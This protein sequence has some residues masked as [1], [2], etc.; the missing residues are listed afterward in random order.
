M[1]ATRSGSGGTPYSARRCGTA[2]C[3]IQVPSVWKRSS[4]S[5]WTT[6][7]RSR[8]CSTSG[9][10]VSVSGGRFVGRR[11]VVARDLGGLPE[12]PEVND[13]RCG[14]VGLALPDELAEPYQDG[15]LLFGGKSMFHVNHCANVEV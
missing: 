1:C 15:S 12:R 13:G 9:T 6:A 7:S 8:Y 2:A 5:S 10:S 11:R 3:Q 4:P 14:G